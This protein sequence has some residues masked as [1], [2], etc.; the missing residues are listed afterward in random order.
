M[1]AAQV[2]GLE[3]FSGSPGL[4]TDHCAGALSI[5]RRQA[6]SDAEQTWTW[7]DPGGLAVEVTSEAIV[8]ALA[9]QALE[10]ELPSDPLTKITIRRRNG[11]VLCTVDR[12]QRTGRTIAEAMHN[13]ALA[14]RVAPR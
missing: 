6:M 12:V 9:W 7:R 4:R 14:L 1:T 8:F 5:K 10:R 3:A 11:Q 13:C 2:K